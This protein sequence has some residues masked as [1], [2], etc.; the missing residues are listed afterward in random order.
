MNLIEIWNKPC[1]ISYATHS[2]QCWLV[3]FQNPTEFVSDLFNLC[4]NGVESMLF[5][6]KH[7]E[8]CPKV[9]CEFRNFV[10]SLC[11]A[12]VQFIPHIHWWPITILSVLFIFVYWLIWNTLFVLVFSINKLIWI[13]RRT[14]ISIKLWRNKNH[15][16]RIIRG[17]NNNNDIHHSR[18]IWI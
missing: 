2:Q 7:E 11:W 4:L 1:S 14:S 5:K 17:I 15:S 6:W 10:N 18:P 12:N 9:N 13:S 16:K 8:K 3:N